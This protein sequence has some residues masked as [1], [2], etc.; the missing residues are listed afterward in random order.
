MDKLNLLGRIHA[1]ESQ[2]AALE[3]EATQANDKLNHVVGKIAVEKAIET[4]DDVCKELDFRKFKRVEDKRWVIKRG[5]NQYLA[6]LSVQKAGTW[7]NELTMSL[8]AK[9]DAAGFRSKEDAERIA[10]FVGGTVE[11]VE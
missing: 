3:Y 5:K 9:R 8:C 6:R 11:E 4:A 2:V 7:G 10:E 1:L